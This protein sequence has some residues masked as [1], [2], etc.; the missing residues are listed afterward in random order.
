MLSD[1]LKIYD[2]PIYLKDSTRESIFVV[3]SIHE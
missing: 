3:G 2:I 1:E